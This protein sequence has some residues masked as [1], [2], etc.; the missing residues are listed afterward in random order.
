MKNTTKRKC[1]Q[2]C[3]EKWFLESD[4]KFSTNQRS[5]F[6]TLQSTYSQVIDMKFYTNGYGVVGLSSY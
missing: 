4:K 5:I 2:Y 6:V 3:P 1:S